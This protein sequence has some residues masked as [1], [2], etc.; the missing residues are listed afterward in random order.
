VTICAA[1]DVGN[2]DP[3]ALVVAN[4]AAQVTLL[5]GMPECQLPLSQ[6]VTYIATAPKSNAAAMAV[7]S[8]AKDVREGRTIPV[9]R[10]LR[11]THYPGAKR[12]GHEGYK[13]AHDHE[14][15]FV[16]QDYLGVDKTYYFP[17]DRGYEA[18][19]AA[20]L[21]RIRSAGREASSESLPETSEG[22]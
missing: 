16:Q 2:A 20:Y 1:E 19:I 5:V 7:W 4:A 17:T 9:P 11:D 13:Y 3:M 12:L 21:A 22:A 14:G 8:A 6:A 15:G 10:H 18:T